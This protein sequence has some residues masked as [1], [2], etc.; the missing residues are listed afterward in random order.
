MQPVHS[1]HLYRSSECRS[2]KIE[3]IVTMYV[4]SLIRKKCTINPKLSRIL[5]KH[6]NIEIAIVALEALMSQPLQPKDSFVVG[7]FRYVYALLDI[8]SCVWGAWTFFALVYKA[9]WVAVRTLLFLSFDTV[10]NVAFASASETLLFFSMGTSVAQL[11]LSIYDLFFHSYNRLLQLYGQIYVDIGSSLGLGVGAIIFE[12][13]IIRRKRVLILLILS[14]LLFMTAIPRRKPLVHFRSLLSIFFSF[15]SR[16]LLII[17]LLLCFI[18]QNLIS[19]PPYKTHKSY[20]GNLI[21]FRIWIP[22][23]THIRMVNF[24]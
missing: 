13:L 20:N 5:H 22:I 10:E 14:L 15:P 3:L 24:C 8:L 23:L 7:I 4:V 11:I 21:K 17:L 2:E 19:L 16:I 18:N 6:G 12:I 9:L 1:P